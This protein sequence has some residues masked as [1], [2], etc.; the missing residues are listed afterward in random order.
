MNDGQRRVT[1]IDVAREAGV[2]R[3]TVSYVLNNDPNQTIPEETQTRVREAARKL[4]Y[5]PYAPARMMRSGQSKIVLVVWPHLVVEESMSE[6]MGQLAAELANIGFNLVWEMGFSGKEENLASNLAPA[7]VVGVVDE[8]DVRAISALQRFKAPI[9]TLAGR[10]WASLA[11]RAQVEYL[12]SR[13]R[14]PIIFAATDQPDLRDLCRLREDIVRQTCR[15]HGVPEPRV[16]TISQSREEA[17]QAVADLLRR[18]APPFAICAFNDVV[19]L[20]ALAALYDLGVAVPAEVSVVGHDNTRIAEL[21][22]PPLTSIGS[23]ARG[24]VAEQLIASVISLCQGK[25]ASE[26]VALGAPK[27]F[28]RASA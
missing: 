1:I 13:D 15:E 23:E 28:V 26:V 27:V 17:R 10:K 4:D 11:P 9:V 24:D 2:S 25:P 8:T 3:T 16:V 22:N 20:A 19:A 6:M 18:Q 7:V 21:S 5:Q 12:L 14:R